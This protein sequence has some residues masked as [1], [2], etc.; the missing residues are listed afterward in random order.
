MRTPGPRELVS[1]S[2]LLSLVLR[3]RPQLLRLTLDDAGWVEVDRLLAALARHGRPLSPAELRLLVAGSDK[4]R[5]A[6]SEDGLRV[7]KN[8]AIRAGSGLTLTT[9][10]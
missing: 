7:A 6:L 3:H 10:F 2:K 8:T 5:F 9:R 4:Q 1:L